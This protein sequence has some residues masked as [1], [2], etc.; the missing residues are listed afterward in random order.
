MKFIFL[1]I[2]LILLAGF[3][4][5]DID[6]LPIVTFGSSP[7]SYIV[8]IN[9][10]EYKVVV[11]ESII[12]NDEFSA[13]NIAERKFIK[14]KISLDK[15]DNAELVI[16][17]KKASDGSI[18]ADYQTLTGV[19][20]KSQEMTR[21]L[22]R[23]LE[24]VMFETNKDA[25]IQG[26]IDSKDEKKLIRLLRKNPYPDPDEIFE[27]IP[28]LESS[29][30]GMKI[31]IN[32][33]ASLLSYDYTPI[34]KGESRKVIL[35]DLYNSNAYQKYLYDYVFNE[36]LHEYTAMG[37]SSRFPENTVE[38]DK[39]GNLKERTELIS[40]P[41][42]RPNRLAKNEFLVTIDGVTHTITRDQELLNGK[43]ISEKLSIKDVNP[44]EGKLFYDLEMKDGKVIGVDIAEVH[45]IVDKKR[46]GGGRALMTMFAEMHR[47][48]PI[49][50]FLAR[51]AE[52]QLLALLRSNPYP[53]LS[54]IREAIPLLKLSTHD[55]EIVLK[56]PEDLPGG[57]MLGERL[58]FHINMIPKKGEQPVL[59]NS[60]ETFRSKKYQKYLLQY[61]YNDNDD[62]YQLAL[63]RNSYDKY[64]I[65]LDDDNLPL[66]IQRKT[67]PLI[68]R[69]SLFDYEGCF[70]QIVSQHLL[71]PE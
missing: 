69:S 22:R 43:V 1:L 8:K 2:F 27:T 68:I 14:Y 64:D 7:N 39:K 29:T 62:A 16:E 25:V 30:H 34:S 26:V 50:T 32:R 51:D 56:G 31:K 19:S 10:S 61:V 60:L 20:S 5:N 9:G 41:Y 40:R 38:F 63:K 37:E 23:S 57:R 71:K 65:V 48:Y 55:L 47:D 11:S 24:A 44:R 17:I 45:G 33:S 28:E 42:I 70:H 54:D 13:E 3:K 18:I 12:N 15:K 58:E 35:E 6:D 49:R 67:D 46:K 66:K 52:D 21:D 36:N 59:L 4:I 53:S